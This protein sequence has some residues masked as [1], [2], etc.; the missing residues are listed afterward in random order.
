LVDLI[1]QKG[2]NENNLGMGCSIGITLL[3]IVMI[4]NLIQLALTGFFKKG[5]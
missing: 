2:F 4:V 1:Y 3:A 5:E